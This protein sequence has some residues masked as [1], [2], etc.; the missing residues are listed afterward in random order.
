MTLKMTT[1]RA[2]IFAGA[3]AIPLAATTSA[4]PPVVIG[5][6]LVNVQIGTIDVQTGDI[7]S[8]NDVQVSVNAAAQIAANVCGVAVAVLAE[9]IATGSPIDCT[10]TGNQVARFVSIN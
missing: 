6:G 10:T 3:L 7:L 5:G 4:Q 9:Q 2:A 8:S 1:V